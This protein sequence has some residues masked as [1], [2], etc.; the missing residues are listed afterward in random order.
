[1]FVNQILIWSKIGP[2]YGVSVV[3][4]GKPFRSATYVTKV[5]LLVSITNN[6]IMTT[7]IYIYIYIYIIYIKDP[8]ESVEGSSRVEI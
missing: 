5:L 2:D 1:M 3:T 7:S 8:V 6:N 4:A